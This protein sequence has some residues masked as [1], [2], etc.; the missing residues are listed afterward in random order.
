LGRSSVWPGYRPGH[1]LI[2]FEVPNA[3][4]ERP[5]IAHGRTRRQVRHTS[6]EGS[7]S[8]VWQP[9]PRGFL[10]ASLPAP[11]DDPL[12]LVCPFHAAQLVHAHESNPGAIRPRESA[13]RVRC[14]RFSRLRTARA[15]PQASSLSRSAI[16]KSISDVSWSHSAMELQSVL[17]VPGA[18]S[19]K[20]EPGV[21]RRAWP[22]DS[23][24]TL[25][26]WESESWGLSKVTPGAARR[27]ESR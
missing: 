14:G 4:Q 17:E 12:P 6:R 23:G 25:P 22:Y 27:T 13:C 20:V 11:F 16:T 21:H 7:G 19:W 3:E 18:S 1:L 15:A 2:G 9:L 8:C 24:D 26:R 10:A 5:A